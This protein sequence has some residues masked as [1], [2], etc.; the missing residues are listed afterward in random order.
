MED[1]EAAPKPKAARKPRKAP[2]PAKPA[3]VSAD[4]GVVL[5]RKAL[6][7][8]VSAS[9]GGKKGTVKDIVEA[10]LKS[11]GDALRAGDSLNLPPLGKARV[12]KAGPTGA[13]GKPAA[14]T[15]KL[16]AHTTA[17]AAKKPAKEALAAGGEEG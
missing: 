10:T 11:I 4:P 12:A 5:T 14:L 3:A 1:D 17:P 9:V 6:I 15:I 8:Q 2:A 16:R 7:E 13:D